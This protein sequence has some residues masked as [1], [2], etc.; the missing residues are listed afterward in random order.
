M[1]GVTSLEYLGRMLS[2]SDK[3]FPAVEQN[4]QKAQGKWGGLEKILG[5]EGENWRMMGRFYVAVV[6]A[7]IIFGSK[8]WLLIPWLDKSLESFHHCVVRRMAFMGLKRQQ[9]QT[10]VYTP[11]GE[12]LATVQLEDI[13]VYID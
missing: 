8:T 7:V 1:G 13:G 12:V 5:S 6:Q 4:L 10:W 3:D 2:S 9:D 11:I